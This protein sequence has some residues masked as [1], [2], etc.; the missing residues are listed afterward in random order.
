VQPRS[1]SR[2]PPRPT[3]FALTVPGNSLIRIG[4]RISLVVTGGSV[5]LILQ[6]LA[7]GAM[8]SIGDGGTDAAGCS[9]TGSVIRENARSAS[10]PRTPSFGIG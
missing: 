8:P 10:P 6:S 5:R 9:S 1:L 2:M 4:E 7:L 3:I